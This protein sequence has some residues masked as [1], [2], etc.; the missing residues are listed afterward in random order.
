V[1]F[2]RTDS[3]K[4]DYQRL[5]EKEREMFRT[6]VRSFNVACD[7]VIETRDSSSWLAD[8]RVKAVVNAPGIFEMTW[9]G[10]GPDGRATWQ[11]ITVTI[12]H[13]E[14]VPAAALAT[15]RWSQYFPRTMTRTIGIRRQAT[16]GLRTRI[17]WT[18][19]DTIRTATMSY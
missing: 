18:L 14:S 12:V 11:W 7:H 1:R 4:G 2:E 13:G 17:L 19:R 15:T 8:L 9:S 10:S 3:F 16:V 5:T 6:A